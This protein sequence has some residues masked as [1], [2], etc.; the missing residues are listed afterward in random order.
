MEALQMPAII[1]LALPSSQTHKQRSILLAQLNRS[2]CHHPLKHTLTYKPS[3]V[4][5]VN[6]QRLEAIK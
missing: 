5:S 2:S 3:S 1:L 6:P 4:S